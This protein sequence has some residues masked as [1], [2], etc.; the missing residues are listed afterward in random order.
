MVGG[1][2]RL[3]TCHRFYRLQIRHVLSRHF[4]PICFE[5]RDTFLTAAAG[6]RFVSR[7]MPTSRNSDDETKQYSRTRF[8]RRA[9]P[10]FLTASSI[11]C[12]AW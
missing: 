11:R 9:D 2:L 3:D 1:M 10:Q 4:K 5:V 7:D 8:F 6:R 12:Q